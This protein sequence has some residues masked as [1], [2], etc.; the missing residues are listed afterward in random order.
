[1]I[2]AEATSS[3]ARTRAVFVANASTMYRAMISP[4]SRDAQRG[5]D[6]YP[7]NGRSA[8]HPTPNAAKRSSF[9][10]SF[11]P[12]LSA[13]LLAAS[14]FASSVIV[15]QG[16]AR[17]ESRRPSRARSG[18]RETS[19]RTRR[20]GRTAPRASRRHARPRRGSSRKR[21]RSPRPER[22]ASRA[23]VGSGARARALRS[24]PA[25]GCRRRAPG[26]EAGSRG[27]WSRRRAARRAR[28]ASG[29]PPR[30]PHTHRGTRSR[31]R[32]RAPT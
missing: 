8:C 21:R 12:R 2:G 32:S 17:R 1:M 5:R 20:G 28:R 27:T 26:Y 16:G 30:P 4:A 19:R 31:A 15:G 10:S 29:T 13:V 11:R 23:G 25:S 3:P 14:S 6:V 18:A 9:D 24:A 7:G 22:R